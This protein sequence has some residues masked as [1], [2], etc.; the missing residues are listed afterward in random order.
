MKQF[1]A[2]IILVLSGCSGD[3]LVA[4]SALETSWIDV[5]THSDTIITNVN[6]QW[7]VIYYAAQNWQIAADTNIAHGYRFIGARKGDTI[8]VKRLDDS[9]TNYQ[10][11]ISGNSENNDTLKSQNFLDTSANNPVKKYIHLR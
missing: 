5:E 7:P 11:Y 8:I 4:P 9:S 3:P 2:C 1:L 6:N 10:T